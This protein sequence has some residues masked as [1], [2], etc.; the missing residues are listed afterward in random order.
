MQAA[1]A[2]R[3][4][5]TA[6][7]AAAALRVA[8]ARKLG[9]TYLDTGALY[10]VVAL[11]VS[12]EP[13]LA[14]LLR[15]GEPTPREDAAL[16]ALASALVIRFEDAGTR[17]WL[18]DREVTAE[19]RT[20]EISQGA[21][22][23]SAATGVRRALLGLQRRLGA[24]GGAVAEGRDVGTV[25][26]PDAEVKFYLTANTDCRA[27]RRVADLEARGIRAEFESTKLEIEQRDA[28][29]RGREVAPLRRPDDAIEIDSGPLTAEEV[30]LRMC[31][32]VTS[33]KGS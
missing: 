32:V 15:G 9:F 7:K 2:P 33:R 22:R 13:D 6:L 12:A 21:S 30:V 28:R 23:V 4:A 10:R 5:V 26:F 24:G 1:K 25:V 17:V 3:K 20:P 8:L 18:A 29:D 14:H 27:R 11:A 16:E 19:I 31:E